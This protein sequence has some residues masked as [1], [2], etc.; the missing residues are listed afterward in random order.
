MRVCSISRTER[1]DKPFKEAILREKRQTFQSFG[2]KGDNPGVDNLFAQVGDNVDSA[3]PADSIGRSA[4]AV[5]VSD[6]GQFRC[7]ASKVAAAT[8]APLSVHKAI[9]G[10]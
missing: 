3:Y 1:R 7:Q 10:K 4:A 5:S 9:G 6:A 8:I 2:E